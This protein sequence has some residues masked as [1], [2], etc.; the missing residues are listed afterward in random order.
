MGNYTQPS[1]VP[2]HAIADMFETFFD[3][4][5]NRT[6]SRR[7]TAYRKYWLY[8]LGKHW[9]YSR[10]ESDPTLTFN[11]CRLLTDLHNNF[12][13]K[14]GFKISIP[15]DPTTKKNDKDDRDFVRVMLEETWRKNDRDLWILEA[16]QGGSITGDVFVRVSW[17]KTDPLED[18]YARV[19]LIPPHFC[20][21]EFSGPHG[22][23]KKK[24]NRILIVNPKY[25]PAD[26]SAMVGPLVRKNPKVMAPVTLKMESEEWIAAQYDRQGNMI[27]P[28]KVK[29]FVDKELI[30]EKVSPIGEIPV[31]HIPNYPLSGEYYGISDLSDVFE[32]NRELNEKATDISDIINYHGSPTTIVSGAKLNDLEKG[33]NRVWSVPE[34]SKVYNLELNGDLRAASE[35]Y[36]KVRSA[37]LELSSTTEQALGHFEGSVPP[38]GVSLQLQ[39]LPMLNKRDVKTTV[40]GLGIRLINRLILKMTA[41][42]NS[43]FGEKLN[44]LEGNPYRNEVIFPDPLPQDERRELEMS[45]ERLIMGISSRKHEL[46]KMGYSQAEIDDILNAAKEDAVDEADG[47]YAPMENSVADNGKFQVNRGGPDQTRGEKIVDDT[48]NKNLEE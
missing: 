36:D 14:G 37:L 24:L 3:D 28:T 1:S 39:Y 12:A 45:K 22:V 38:S 32:L 19:D 27:S 21:P 18:P 20:F 13:F 5:I 31:V 29:Y 6:H 16:A 35:H 43:S 2:S 30:E 34:N 42:G 17:D 33:A 9:S 11:Y 25:V 40:Y 23:N 47:L 48:V 8:Y 15:D 4:D 10:G 44:A 7:L 41:I 46:E 26:P